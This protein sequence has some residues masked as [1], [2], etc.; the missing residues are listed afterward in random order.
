MTEE[1]LVEYEKEQQNALRREQRK[2]RMLSTQMTA[3]G[4]N[5]AKTR[6]SVSFPRSTKK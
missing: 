2:S 1:E 5:N 6:M 3:Y 4:S